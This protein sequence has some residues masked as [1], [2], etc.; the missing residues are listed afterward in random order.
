MDKSL[1][2]KIIKKT[3]WCWCLCYKTYKFKKNRSKL[4]VQYKHLYE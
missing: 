1:N 3:R 2:S 4:W